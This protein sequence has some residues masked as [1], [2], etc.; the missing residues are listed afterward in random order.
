MPILFHELALLTPPVLLPA[1]ALVSLDCVLT[2]RCHGSSTHEQEGA[3]PQRSGWRRQSLE[4]IRLSSLASVESSSQHSSATGGVPPPGRRRLCR[5]Q[6]GGTRRPS[7]TYA[8]SDSARRSGPYPRT[9]RTPAG[10]SFS[11]QTPI[12]PDRS[13][14]CGVNVTSLPCTVTFPKPEMHGLLFWAL[15]ATSAGGCNVDGVFAGRPAAHPSSASASPDSTGSGPSARP[16]DGLDSG[17]QVH[18]C[19]G[20]PVSFAYRFVSGHRRDGKTSTT[21]DGVLSSDSVRVAYVSK[22]NGDATASWNGTI[23]GP[24]FESARAALSQPLTERSHP[25]GARKPNGG[26]TKRLQVTHS[27]DCET[28]GNQAMSAAFKDLLAEAASQARVGKPAKSSNARGVRVRL[29][30]DHP[31][32]ELR[33]ANGERF[34]A[35]PANGTAIFPKPASGIHCTV[36]LRGGEPV[37]FGPVRV[38]ARVLC[39]ETDGRVSC[40]ED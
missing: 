36:H 34:R 27:D 15:L 24:V 8:C 5:P 31:Y 12:R 28:R 3:H 18:S 9:R 32:V 40:R 33:C 35:K 10:T 26:S 11:S 14:T 25:K 1:I 4:R 38:P 23:R 7:R 39:A 22:L 13:R 17:T 20:K 16:R 37:S 30:T 21:F 6:E 19:L 29:T 2:G